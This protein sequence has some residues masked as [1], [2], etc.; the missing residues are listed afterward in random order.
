M[1]YQKPF[2]DRELL[3]ANSYG[4]LKVSGLANIDTQLKIKRGAGGDD[5]VMSSHFARELGVLKEMSTDF[6]D[7]CLRSISGHLT[8]VMGVVRDV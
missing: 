3:F 7:P 1:F 2:D 6:A 8:P 5:L 4:S